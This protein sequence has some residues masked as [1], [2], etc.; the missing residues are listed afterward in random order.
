MNWYISGWRSRRGLRLGLSYCK[1]RLVTFFLCSY[2]TVIAAVLLPLAAPGVTVAHPTAEER[3]QP[4]V[5]SSR[6]PSNH[7]GHRV[8]C[9]TFLLPLLQLFLLNE[10]VSLC[11]YRGKP[12]TG[13]PRRKTRLAVG[14]TALH[15][16]QHSFISTRHC[17]VDV[18]KVLAGHC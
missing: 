11:C 5:V 9:R 2:F 15:Y 14:S 7:R 17:V 18:Q 3:L 12:W 16:N 6:P 4:F 13:A 10:A 1:F 8:P